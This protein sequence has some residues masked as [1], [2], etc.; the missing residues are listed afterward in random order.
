MCLDRRDGRSVLAKEG[1]PAQ[2]VSYDIVADPRE[3]T[4]SIT[5]PGK[6]VLLKLTDEPIPPEP[7]A[8]AGTQAAAD[9]KLR[10]TK[11][12]QKSS[13]PSSARWAAPRRSP[14][15]RKQPRPPRRASSRHRPR[16]PKRTRTV[17]T[18]A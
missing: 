4:V 9:G 12:P 14:V 8:Q 16:L 2:T 17:G 6:A 11:Q 1:I 5:M 13:A 15:A 18:P 7:P 3:R 10:S